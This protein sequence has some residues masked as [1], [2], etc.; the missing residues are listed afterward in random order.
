MGPPREPH[1]SS[2]SNRAR[3]RF[4]ERRRERTRAERPQKPQSLFKRRRPRTARAPRER[5]ER[6]ERVARPLPPGAKPK[7]ALVLTVSLLAFL[8]PAALLAGADLSGWLYPPPP[9]PL[10]TVAPGDAVELAVQG[11]LDDGSLFLPNGTL[12]ATIGRGDLVPGFESGLLGLGVGDR[13]DLVVAPADG[14]GL[15]NASRLVF[16]QRFENT[17]RT[18]Q[19]SSTS[20]QRIGGTPYVG[21]RVATQPWES[22]VTAVAPGVVTLRYEPALNETAS[23]YLYWP[24]TVIAVD[25]TTIATRNELFIGDSFDIL[26]RSTGKIIQVRVTGENATA[27]TL[28]LNPP[29]AGQTLHYAGTVMGIQV[30]PGVARSGGGAAVGLGSDTCE[31]CHVGAGFQAVDGSASATRVGA[32]VVVNL[33]VEDPW[34]HEV[35]QIHATAYGGNVSAPAAVAGADLASLGPSGSTEASLRLDTG[36]NAT[37]V[38][39]VVNA[40]AHHIHASGGKPTDLPYQLTFKVPVGGASRAIEAPAPTPAAVPLWVLAGRV[41]GFAALGVACLSA[42]Q[43]YRRHLHRPPRI[44]WPPWVTLHFSV[45]LFAIVLTLIHAV[46]LM[47]STYRGVWTW[48]IT[49]GVIS[50]LALGVMGV[51][52]VILARWTPLRY[53][54]IRKW[55]YWL[56]LGMLFTGFLHTA[57][58]GTTLR[59]LLG[60]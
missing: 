18:F 30:G 28:D 35:Q 53:P 20:F 43:G 14:F 11:H 22:T 19:L 47:S 39:V 50:L 46:A 23:L 13:F 59:M 32:A 1:D 4:R 10:P 41:T 44:K 21:E 36:A 24:S 29:L 55:H 54:G 7:T 5:S 12:N 26:S 33:T 56:M 42:V 57:V 40:T 52:G 6:V 37:T 58:S 9:P 31:R 48:D 45:S 27:F 3:A 25:N 38:T 16:I 15:W 17:S 51:T 60:V 34:Q 2:R 49:V 8:V